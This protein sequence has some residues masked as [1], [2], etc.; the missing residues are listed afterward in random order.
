MSQSS[1][2][3]EVRALCKKY[4]MGR[5]SHP[6]T[7]REAL[8]DTFSRIKPRKGATPREGQ[9]AEDTSFEFWALRDFSL[10]VYRGETIG[11]VGR[12]GAGKSTLLKILARV[13]EPTSGRI[14]LFGRV[15]SLLEVGTGFH[16]ELT[17]RENI[18]LSGAVLGMSRAETRTKFDAIVDFA[19]IGAFLDTPVKRYSSGMF[20]RLAFAVAAHLEPDILLVDE[21]LAVGDV[22]FQRKCIS[23]MRTVA[24]EGITVVFV[25]HNLGLMR[26]LC[27]R[28]ILLRDGSIAIDGSPDRVIDTY[29]SDL[30]R[31][32]TVRIGDR[33]DRS[34]KG[35]LS[36]KEIKIEKVS[37]TGSDVLVTGEPA[38][39]TFRTSGYCP[40]MACSFTVYDR[41]GHPVTF[42]DSANV[43]W[44]DERRTGPINELVCEIE[45]LLLLPGRYRINAAISCDGEIQDHV[46]AAAFLEVEQGELDGRPTPVEAGYGQVALRHHWIT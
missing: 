34:G 43:G 35:R 37:V 41:L 45:D 23:K 31:T 28:A 6:T 19:E 9:A 13:T 42:F 3:F 2:A 21:V 36:I 16:P 39:F 25:S 38:R 15:G 27:N 8:S 20:V 17:G 29:L 7:L 26:A 12:N 32:S 11:I 33:T 24:R 22:A 30:E 40:G 4:R 10:S 5:R 18:F 44:K 46:E 14:D 1:P